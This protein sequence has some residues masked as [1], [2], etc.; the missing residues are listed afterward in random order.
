M[1]KS[2]KAL[3]KAI[4]KRE[5][6][7]LERLS[8]HGKGEGLKTPYYKQDELIELSSQ[9]FKVSYA[10]HLSTGRDIVR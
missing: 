3:A 2:E 10:L 1:I 4:A 7:Y 5:A 9:I 8:M 6:I